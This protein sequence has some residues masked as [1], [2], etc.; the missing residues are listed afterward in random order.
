MH[1]THQDTLAADIYARQSQGNAASIEQQLE[2]GHKRAAT[3][4]WTVAATYTD[5]ESASRHAA[6]DRENWPQ[7]RADITTGRAQ[8]IWLW[9]SSRGDRRASTW[10]AML[11]DCRAAEVRIYVE[12]HGRLYDMAN[13]RDWRNMAED[14]T[15]NEYESE[16]IALRVRR[17]MADRAAKGLVHARAP[18][19]YRREYELTQEGKRVLLGQVPVPAEAEVVRRVIK[20]VANGKSLRS[21]TADLNDDGVP[22]PSGKPWT[23]GRVRDIAVN[24]AYAGKRAHLPGRRGGHRAHPD[25]T[26]TDATWPALVEVAT[27]YDAYRILTDPARRT[28]RP[29]KATHLLSLIARCG[30]CGGLLTVTYRQRQGR[31]PTYTCRDRNCIRID[32]ADL[33]QHVAAELLA[34]FARPQVQA[35]IRAAEVTGNAELDAAKAELADIEAQLDGLRD[36]ARRRKITPASFAAIEPGVVE[37]LEAAR[38]RV[39]RLAVPPVARFLTDGAGDLAIR[40]RSAPVSARRAFVR[41]FATVTVGRSP[42]AGHRVDPEQRVQ[43]KYT[44]PPGVTGEH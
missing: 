21:I 35:R 14:G 12:T 16:K 6:K 10:L 18:Y 38:A 9:E 36:Q 2:A 17:S 31:R 40:W 39:A 22:T 4:G 29:G 5:T 37:D 3:E 20:A 28:S 27:W 44:A 19:G 7:L 23:P 30:V 24:P 43:I 34:W 33:D 1:G 42:S 13:P 26:L 41:A 8:V 25:A 11:E 15:D 32:E